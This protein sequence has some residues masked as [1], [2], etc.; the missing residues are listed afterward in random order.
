[1]QVLI[2]RNAVSELPGLLQLAQ[3]P[4][5]ALGSLA[6]NVA[7]QLANEAALPS[8]LAL[9]P[10]ISNAAVREAAEQAVNR[11]LPQNRQ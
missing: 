5:P 11:S 1:M 2:D 8:L 10:K 7:G 9:F 4:N 3:E 6:L